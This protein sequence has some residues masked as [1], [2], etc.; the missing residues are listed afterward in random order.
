MRST[1]QTSAGGFEIEMIDRLEQMAFANAQ[2]RAGELDK[3]AVA[4]CPSVDEEGR[5]HGVLTREDI[6]QVLKTKDDVTMAC[7]FLFVSK[8]IWPHCGLDIFFLKN[9]LFDKLF[10]ASVRNSLCANGIDDWFR[11]R[12]GSHG[13]PRS[14]VL[15]NGRGRNTLQAV[16]RKPDGAVFV[17]QIMADAYA[18]FQIGFVVG[19]LAVL[20]KSKYGFFAK[21]RHMLD[22]LYQVQQILADLTVVLSWL[23]HDRF[24]KRNGSR[25]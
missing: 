3:D 20:A 7:L 23:S 17:G 12:I 10:G 22:V 25:R 9:P 6:G 21:P 16:D 4:L 14:D 11:E 1:N 2:V 8:A 24:S 19:E 13:N 5:I 18:A 15:G